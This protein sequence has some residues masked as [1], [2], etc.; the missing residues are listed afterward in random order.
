MPYRR[1]KGIRKPIEGK[2]GFVSL[3]EGKK[4]FVS[5]IEGKNSKKKNQ[6]GLLSL[7]KP[8]QNSKV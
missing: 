8:T 1:Q 4:G 6:A 2:K 3:I 7:P 5:L